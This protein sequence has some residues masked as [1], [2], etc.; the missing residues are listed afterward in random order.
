MRPM[1]LSPGTR[2]GPY[3]IGEPLGAGGMGEVYRALD[4]RLE[5][6]V[7]IKILPGHLASDP[8]L[9]ARF[10]REAR[11]VSALSH[12]HICTLHDIGEQDG[13][14]YLVMEHLEGETLVRRL[15]RGPL[16]PEEALRVAVQIAQALA[17]AHR[18]GVIHRDLKP[19]N[20]VLTKNGAKL[21]DFGLAKQGPQ[22]APPISS[23]V[24]TE[25]SP[26]T[27]QGTL[28]GTWQYMSPEQ[29]EG[30]EA[31]AR[32]DIFAFGAVL[33]E[34]M[35]G[36]RAFEGRS[37][38]S[39]IAAIMGTH[40][41]APSSVAP[42]ISPA[43]DRVVRRCL[44]KEPDDR[45]QSAADLASD[46]KWIEQGSATESAAGASLAG[47]AAP[48]AASARAESRPGVGASS[49][50]RERLFWVVVSVALLA[51]VAALAARTFLGPGEPPPPVTAAL[52]PPAGDTFDTRFAPAVSPD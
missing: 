8:A 45:W 52:L 21:L 15:A 4:T 28:V 13:V 38:A 3:E 6:T 50:K 43:L 1:A 40:P 24:M 12:P 29:L 27:A 41:P 37:Q 51:T 33:Y 48:S 46:L 35:T 44:A 9:R 7:A 14:H 19:G 25:L 36:R 31:D 10:E 16:P 2:L 47:V 39:L 30:S 32:S 26:L 5:R 17:L 22:A 23:A 49:V 11:A 42:G 34:M 18:Q 20:I